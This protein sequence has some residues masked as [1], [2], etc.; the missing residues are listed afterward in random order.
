MNPIALFNDWSSRE[1]L[2]FVKIEVQEVRCRGEGVQARLKPN[3]R[4]VRESSPGVN[5]EFCPSSTLRHFHLAPT[6]VIPSQP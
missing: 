2:V 4:R 3:L 1:N 6:L 5:I